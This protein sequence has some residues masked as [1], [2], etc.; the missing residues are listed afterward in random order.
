MLHGQLGKVVNVYYGQVDSSL[1]VKYKLQGA[2][3]SV[4]Q[5]LCSYGG[6]QPGSEELAGSAPLGRE[7]HNYRNLQGI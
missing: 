4:L 6:I 7:V 5:D 3:C 1:L 2:G